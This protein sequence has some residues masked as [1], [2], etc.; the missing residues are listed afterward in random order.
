VPQG[1]PKVAHE[2]NVSI[3][4]DGLRKTIKFDNL[5]KIKRG[6]LRSIRSLGTRDKVS[7][8]LES[9]N[10]YE[11]E[12]MF[13]QGVG[14]TKHKIH[15]HILPRS[16]RNR[17]RGVKTD[18]LLMVFGQLTLTTMPNY[19]RDNTLKAWPIE[20]SLYLHNGL[21]S[22]KMSSKPT[23]MQFPHEEISH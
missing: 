6:N 1:F 21:I 4:Y 11:N 7:H 12:V 10:H 18:V 19:L 2:P 13:L 14:E 17:K 15:A 20:L 22:T 23:C 8:F 16:V 3:G 5:V 9:V